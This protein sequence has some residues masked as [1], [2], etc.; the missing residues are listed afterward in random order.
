[1]VDF[2]SE[3]V[4]QSYGHNSDK[5]N[6]GKNSVWGG[7]GGLEKLELAQFVQKQALRT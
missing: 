2:G 7:W 4:N 5:K 1:M 3:C 6:T